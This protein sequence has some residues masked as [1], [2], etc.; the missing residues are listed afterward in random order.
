MRRPSDAA[1]VPDDASPTNDVEAEAWMPNLWAY[2]EPCSRWFYPERG[3]D[4]GAAR[5]AT[6]PVCSTEAVTVAEEPSA[7]A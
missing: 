6:C 4:D 5:S 3:S 1:P 7:W 2:C